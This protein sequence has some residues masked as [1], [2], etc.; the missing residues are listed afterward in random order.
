MNKKFTSAG[1]LITAVAVV[2]LASLVLFLPSCKKDVFDSDQL[3]EGVYAPTWALPVIYSDL[4]LQDM[5]THGDKNGVISIGPDKFCTLIYKGLL[6]SLPASSVVQLPNQSQPGYSVSLS[7]TEI[8]AL[9]AAGTV[10]TTYTQTIT[11]SPGI[12]NPEIDSIVFKAGSFDML[13][14]SSFTFSGQVKMT[15]PSLKLNGIPF[16]N[17]L[18]FPYVG[19][20]PVNASGKYPLAGY[21]MDLTKGGTTFNQFDVVYQV[22]LSGSGTPPTTSDNVFLFQSF[23]GMQYSYLFGYLG[24]VALSPDQDTVNL[25]IFKNA[26][27]NGT[28]TLVDPSVFVALSNSFGFPISASISQLDGF[29]PPSNVYPITGSPSPL[30]INSPNFTQIGQTLAGSYSLTSTN[31]N[32]VSVINNT[33][34]KIIYKINSQSNP[35]G[36]SHQNFITDSSRFRVDMQVN[37]PFWG[38]AQDFSMEDTIDFKMDSALAENVEYLLFHIYNKNGF[39]IDV[40]MQAYL[41]DSNYVKVDSLINPN[42]LILKSAAINTATG[43][44]TTP[45]EK[46]LDITVDNA[47]LQ[48]WKNVEQI[49]LRSTAATTNQAA[50]D[51]KL[52]SYYNIIAKLG[53]KAKLKVKF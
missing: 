2:F 9:Q 14:N 53:V 42:Q 6:F 15:I 38:T 22:T 44:V 16:S 20:V 35:A 52:Y 24:Q 21:K 45:T 27:G 23:T 19:N 39:P 28:Y 33:P 30:P 13:L 46:I 12:N 51:V 29:N 40:D 10:T 47:R 26:L 3:A 48:K 4:S 25:S 8:A 34:K 7:A 50:S 1:T 37:L 36:P 43:M 18:S 49:I 32:I 41:I 11:F 31:S 17:T 5:I